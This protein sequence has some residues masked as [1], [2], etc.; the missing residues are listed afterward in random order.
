MFLVGAVAVLAYFCGCKATCAREVKL[1]TD[2]DH[3]MFPP[4]PDSEQQYERIKSI[5]DSFSCELSKCASHQISC[6][7][8]LLLFGV[9]PSQL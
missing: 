7:G 2:A 5:R 4:P 8:F 9:P 1:V 6:F 3:S